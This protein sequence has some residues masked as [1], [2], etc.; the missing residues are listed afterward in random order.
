MSTSQARP[1]FT[2][3]AKC[4]AMDTDYEK[5]GALLPKNDK[6]LGQKFHEPKKWGE[7]RRQTIFPPCFWLVKL[8][9][10][11]GCIPTSLVASFMPLGF[12]SP[13]SVPYPSG[14]N[15]WKSA[16]NTKLL[17]DLFVASTLNRC[18]FCWSNSHLSSFVPISAGSCPFGLVQTTISDC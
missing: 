1:S 3:Q 11:C 4:A 17:H 8:P 12:C 5:R 16:G 2:V 15:P 9:I 7:D 13:L 14:S 10:S 18:C 6:T